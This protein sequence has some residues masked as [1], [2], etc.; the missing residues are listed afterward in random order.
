MNPVLIS[1]ATEILFRQ[2][3][4]KS[5]LFSRDRLKK[6]KPAFTLLAISFLSFFFLLGE[7]AACLRKSEL[8]PD[9]AIFLMDDIFNR[10]CLINNNVSEGSKLRF[11]EHVLMNR[12]FLS[13]LTMTINNIL[14]AEVTRHIVIKMVTECE[15]KPATKT[16]DIKSVTYMNLYSGANK[17]H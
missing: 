8:R 14:S 12:Y 6:S 3:H 2:D 1:R 7:N 13:D 11:R 15:S 16:H 10:R 4:R 9:E 17:V 5:E